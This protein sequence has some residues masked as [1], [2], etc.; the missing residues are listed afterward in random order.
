MPNNNTLLL[1]RGLPGSGK[2]TLLELFTSRFA[3]FCADDFFMVDGEYIFDPSK[4]TQA[5]ALCLRH[6][7]QNLMD[8]WLNVV[9]GA[10]VHN[11]FTQRWEMEP[12]IQLAEETGARLVVIDLFD[13]GLTD[14]EL[15]AR[16]SH[17]VPMEAIARM[18]A[19]YEHD[20]KH[21]NPLPPWERGK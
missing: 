2:T 11:T 12:Y 13:G 18:R 17:G 3:D 1:I 5:H 20:W 14:K 6:T 16:N 10:A 15:A 7:R 19:R 21:G 4:L 8:Q 9:G